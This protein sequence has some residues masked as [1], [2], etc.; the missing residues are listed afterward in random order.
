[1]SAQPPRPSSTPP[2]HASVLIELVE[3]LARELHPTQEG[4]RVRL[5]TRLDA[6]AG[7]DSLARVELIARLEQQLGLHVQEQAVMAA[8]TVRDLLGALGHRPSGLTPVP[9]PAVANTPAAPATLAIPEQAGTLVDVLG[10]HARKHGDWPHIQLHG[11]GDALETLTYGQLLE[12]AERVAAG[13]RD[14]GLEPGQTAALM[15]PTGREFFLA[16]F[17]ILLAGA[18][19]VPIYPPMRMAQIEDHLRRQTAIL[20]NAQ[21]RLL[22]TVPEAQ[23]VGRLLRA[24]LPDLTAVLS[25]SELTRCGGRT[26]VA[27]DAEALALLQYTSGS[28]GTP[29]GVMLTHANLLANIRA[30]GQVTEA[31]S[32][33][34]FVSWL[35]LYHDMGLIGAWLGSLYHGCRYVVMPP[36]SFIARPQRWLWAIDRHRG[37]LSAGPNFAYE[38]CAS[39]IDPAELRGL[40]L[41]SWRLAFN[42]AEPVSPATIRRFTER[43]AAY[44]FRAV[45]MTPVYGLAECSVGL[46]FPPL[47][48]GP[49]VERVRRD[50][51]L[52]HGQVEPAGPDDNK[53]LLHVACGRPL[54]HHQ[55]RVVAPDGH[56]LAEREEG[57]IEFRGPSATVGY[58]RNPEATA[59][60]LRNG[61]LDS[62][63]YGYLAGGELYVSGRA[64]ELIIRA[65]RN[66]Y[67]YE[68]EDAVGA[69]P[70]VRKGNVA[71]FGSVDPEQGTERLIVLAETRLRH[72]SKRA[73]LRERIQALVTELTLTPPDEIVLAPP[74]SVLKTSS[75]KIRRAA[76]RDLYE[77]GELGRQRAPWVQL[78]RLAAAGT[79]P[80]LRRGWRS[81]RHVL[82]GA[83]AWGLL[84]TFALPTWLAVLALRE[85]TS[86]RRVLAAAG[87]A[88]L[89]LTGGSL[90]VEGSEHLPQDGPC[91]VVANHASYIDSL[92][93]SVVMPERFRFVAKR[94]LVDQWFARL[95]LERLGTQ[96]VE[97][98]DAAAGVRDAERVTRAVQDGAAMVFFP[99]GTFTRAPGLRPFRLGAFTAAV[100]AGAPVIPVA[101]QGTRS[102]LPAGHWLPR[103]APIRVTFTPPLRPQGG[104]WRAALQLR[105]AARAQILRHCGEPDLVRA[106]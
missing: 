57:R 41:S 59:R 30:M 71:V 78:V 79:G 63:D 55:V 15:L 68:L 70:G 69:L 102:V 1:L 92:V 34:V 99:E 10:W 88:V 82:Y 84:A 31:S 75:G 73:E 3:Q 87:R 26:Q 106:T 104:D 35:P 49:R 51:F 39:R 24:Q 22:I 43:F 67:P 28:T 90:S 101:I 47:E 42:G 72:E 60:L 4:Q 16:F 83:Y 53:P 105:D 97:R 8:H 80:Q 89:H 27:P 65:G 19:P 40:D 52:Q 64:K 25:V 74:R 29:K 56:E 17:G 86:R 45:S 37:T 6:E 18:V 66:I 23:L 36:L 13:L 50:A 48:R 96:F 58:Y 12:G 100:Q 14:R 62:G 94:E 32:A 76:C 61:W 2:V 93:L 33:D 38:L 85:E 81:V 95:F 20:G 46:S 54:P 7:I 103:R 91:V 44:G 21:A 11:D 98:F 9:R 5:D 77:R